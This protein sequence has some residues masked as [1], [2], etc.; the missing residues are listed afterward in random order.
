MLPSCV[1]PACTG[2][3]IQSVPRESLVFV[4]A[5]TILHSFVTLVLLKT[6]YNTVMVQTWPFNFAPECIVE[7]TVKECDV[8]N[9]TH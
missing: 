9:E 3:P 6:N 1:V 7:K 4:V 2:F 8:S 5:M